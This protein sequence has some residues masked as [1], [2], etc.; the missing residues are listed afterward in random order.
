MYWKVAGEL[1]EWEEELIN[2][3]SEILETGTIPCIPSNMNLY[4]VSLGY[5]H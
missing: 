3:A 1:T 5:C 2:Q 4:I